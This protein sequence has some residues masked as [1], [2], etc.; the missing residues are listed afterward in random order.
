MHYQGG[1]HPESKYIAPFLN[2]LRRPGQTYWE[3][4]LGAAN[5][6]T[7]LTGDGLHI[8]SDTNKDLICMWKALQN[9]WVPPKNVTEEEYQEAKY[10]LLLSPELSAYIGIG[11][12]WGGK[13]W[14][15]YARNRGDKLYSVYAYN[16]CLRKAAGIPSNTIFYCMDYREWLPPPKSLIYADPPYEGRTRFR[17]Q[18]DFSHE[19]FWQWCRYRAAE[20]HTVCVSSFNAPYDFETVLQIAAG[21]ETRNKEGRRKEVEHIFMHCSDEYFVDPIFG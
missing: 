18:P 9:G 21:T 11:C 20:G 12:S 15:G 2:K 8:G 1:K 4:F 3:P 16:S 5:V 13:W 14:G 19:E 10:D 7:K 17:G 6:L